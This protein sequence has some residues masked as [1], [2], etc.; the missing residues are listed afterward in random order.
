SS[1]FLLNVR[2]VSDKALRNLQNYVREGGGVA[3]FLGDRV[4]PEFYNKKLYAGGKGIFPAPLADRPYPPISEKELEPDLLDGQLKL[5]VRDEKNPIFA[6][7][8]QPAYRPF[9]QFLPIK[10]YYPVPRRNW[11]PPA[12]MVEELATLPNHR[13]MQDYASEGQAIMDAL[14]QAINDPKVA[15]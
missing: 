4:N 11:N 7:V 15:K 3:F 8:W 13:A 10:R 12:G 6:E 1:V 2:D 5:F 9:F 14:N